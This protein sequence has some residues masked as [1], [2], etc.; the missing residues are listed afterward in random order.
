MVF[1]LGIICGSLT[2]GLSKAIDKSGFIKQLQPYKV[3]LFAVIFIFGLQLFRTA[4]RLFEIRH[5][6]RY[7]YS[8]S[9]PLPAATGPVS[10]KPDI[11]YLVFDRYTSPEVLKANFNFDNSGITNFLAEQGFTTRSQ[12]YSNYPFTTPSIA[13]TL[14]MHYFPQLEKQFGRDGRWQSA[15]PYRT[16]LKQPANSPRT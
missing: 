14:S 3:L 4:G 6:L 8:A 7:E 16:I 15:A 2:W 9:T 12:A 13:S 10:A 5:Q 11:Y 1:L